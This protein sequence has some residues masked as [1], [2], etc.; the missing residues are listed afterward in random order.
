MSREQVQQLWLG[1]GNKIQAGFAE[2]LRQYGL[3]VNPFETERVKQAW[4][5]PRGFTMPTLEVQAERIKRV[6]G[7]EL[8]YPHEAQDMS[9]ATGEFGADGIALWPTLPTLGKLWDIFD[10]RVHGYGEVITAICDAINQSPDMA[11]LTNYCEGK[12]DQRYVHIQPEIMAKLV[13]L[14]DEAERQGF[15]ALVMPVNL[16]DWKTGWCYSSRNAR[17]QCINL[18]PNRL[19][20]EPVACLSLLIAIMERLDTLEEQL[21]CNFTGAEYSWEAND[22][23]SYPLHAHFRKP[24]AV[25]EGG[26][27]RFVFSYGIADN[28]HHQ[29]GAFVGFPGVPILTA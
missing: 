29:Y 15:N 5:Y 18:L 1:R 17:W 27:G 3:P 9:F 19:A 14:E 20:I 13:P 2:V 11:T 21:F 12:L 25:A 8:S 4:Y 26:N 22:C 28:A 10:P 16:G 6:L 23:W 7:V 24:H